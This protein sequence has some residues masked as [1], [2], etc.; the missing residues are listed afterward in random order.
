M[1]QKDYK[2]KLDGLIEEHN[3][4][5]WEQWEYKFNFRD[6]KFYW[7]NQRLIL[8]YSEAFHLYERFVLNKKPC[9][10][11]NPQAFYKLRCKYGDSFLQET[12]HKNK[13]HKRGPKELWPYKIK[14][15]KVV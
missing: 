12:Y 4:Y 7:K 13:S 3:E 14:D 9:H 10:T 1:R 15:G 8:K 2:N 6:F 5:L 11:L